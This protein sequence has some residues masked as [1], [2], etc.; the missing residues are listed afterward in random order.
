MKAHSA[1][2]VVRA[3]AAESRPSPARL[4]A[5]ILFMVLS[6]AL[7]FVIGKV[8]LREIPAMVLP[9]MRI[10]LAALCLVPVYLW[11]ARRGPRQRWTW[12]DAPQLAIVS[13]CGITFNQFFFIAGLSRTSVGHSAVIIALTPM[14]VLALAAVAGQERITP[15]KVAGM[16]IA[17]AGVG[18]LQVSKS[19]AAAATPLGDLYAFVGTLAFSLYVVAGKA[20]STRYGS[21]AVNTFAY[22]VGALTLGPLAW[23]ERSSFR[24]SYLS[25]A[26]W[27]SLAYMAVFPSVIAY[28]IY[29]HALAYM[30]ASRVSMFT[31]AQPILAT[32]LGFALLGEPVT[33]SLVTGGALV[34]AG[35]WVAELRA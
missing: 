27:W 12:A 34:L 32:L 6:W 20:L 16:T 21:I 22:W 35:V 4:Y 24:L 23:F 19:S 3:Q 18:A 25:A 15:A 13:V 2:R 14:L 30:P 33:P 28:L 17:L 31:Y 7:N 5:L 29:Y 9:G 11:D 8:A 26:A 1:Q 10:G